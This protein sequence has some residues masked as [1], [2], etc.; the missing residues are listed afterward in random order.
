M[1]RS[2]HLPESEL[3][4]SSG[5][6]SYD[7][8]PSSYDSGSSSDEY[9]DLSNYSEYQVTIVDLPGQI[10]NRKLWKHPFFWIARKVAKF[11]RFISLRSR[12][13]V[14]S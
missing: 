2:K 7:S 14:Y 9:Q 1:S 4:T 8:G 13:R 6:S 10:I 12:H 11:N 3:D 5:P